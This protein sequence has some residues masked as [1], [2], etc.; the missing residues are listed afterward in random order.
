MVSVAVV[1]QLQMFDGMT[2][3]E[4]LSLMFVAWTAFHRRLY[5]KSEVYTKCS[6]C[7][8]ASS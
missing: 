7:T 4:S 1:L 2:A 5:L 3:L 8:T 6:V